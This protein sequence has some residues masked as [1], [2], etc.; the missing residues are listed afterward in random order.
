MCQLC[1]VQVWAKENE[2]QR[3]L[4]GMAVIFPRCSGDHRHFLWLAFNPEDQTTFVFDVR[5]DER[6]KSSQSLLIHFPESINGENHSWHLAVFFWL[7]SM[8]DPW[9][10]MTLNTDSTNGGKMSLREAANLSF[11]D[12]FWRAVETSSTLKLMCNCSSGTC[13]SRV[14]QEWRK[15]C[16]PYYPEATTPS[17]AT[18]TRLNLRRKTKREKTHFLIDGYKIDVCIFVGSEKNQSIA[19]V[20]DSRRS[21]ASV[22]KR[23]ATN[24]KILLQNPRSVFVDIFL[25]IRRHRN[26]SRELGIGCIFN[27]M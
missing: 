6:N 22:H 3:N 23:T 5:L 10:T 16:K 2:R 17:S 8:L 25:Q 9:D 12:I 27:A 13:K 4:P 18:G 20:T 21:P 24:T 14:L 7:R 11:T 15:R 26:I 19:R 1:D